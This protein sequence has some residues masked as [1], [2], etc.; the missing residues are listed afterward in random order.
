M[1]RFERLAWGWLWWYESRNTVKSIIPP[2]DCLFDFLAKTR[3]SAEYSLRNIAVCATENGISSF[4]CELNLKS[5]HFILLLKLGETIAIVKKV[6]SV[7]SVWQRENSGI[8]VYIRFIQIFI[9]RTLETTHILTSCYRNSG[10]N[11]NN[12]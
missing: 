10:L 7:R 9:G 8:S 11:H 6:C 5:W 3:G 4:P 12:S 1:T 2:L